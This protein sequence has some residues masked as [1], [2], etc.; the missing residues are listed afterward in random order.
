M[1]IKY[2]SSLSSGICVGC[3]ISITK[4]AAGFGSIG[5]APLAAGASVVAVDDVVVPGEAAT[6]AEGAEAA[7]ASWEEEDEE[8]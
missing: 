6:L 7:V 3:L 4:R 8:E 5:G 1:K 2:R